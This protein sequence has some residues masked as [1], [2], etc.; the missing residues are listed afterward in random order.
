[1]SRR[2]L[3]STAAALVEV[4]LSAWVIVSATNQ[5]P[6]RSF[7]WARKYDPAVMFI[8]NWRFFAP[9]PAVHDFR[10]AH[11]LL[12]EDGSSTEW[13]D[14]KTVPRRSWFN[15]VWF[16]SRRRD[17][18]ITDMSNSLIERMDER[19]TLVEESLAYK[20]LR[21]LVRGVVAADL[22]TE[23]PRPNGFQFALGRDAGYDDSEEPTV[24]FTSRFELWSADS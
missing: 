3:A 22:G 18:A 15:T 10:L 19:N 8:P 21:N 24:F 5:L 17:K 2:N 12:L 23:S 11:R 14:T 20:S 9:N 6:N 16:P 4:G 1:M 7:D 13:I